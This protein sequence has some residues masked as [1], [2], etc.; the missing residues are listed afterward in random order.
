MDICYSSRCKFLCPK[1]GLH[2]TDISAAIELDRLGFDVLFYYNGKF[3]GYLVYAGEIDKVS[4]ISLDVD[5]GTV[6]YCRE[7]DRY[8]PMIQDEV[9]N[10]KPLVKAIKLTHSEF[11][12]H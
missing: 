12:V 9:F 2:T 11:L 7:M 1:A 8:I 3:V 6:Y 5:C 4:D 10:S